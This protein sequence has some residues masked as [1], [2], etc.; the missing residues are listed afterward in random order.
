MQPLM[1]SKLGPLI[2]SLIW[3]N[4]G[5]QRDLSQPLMGYPIGVHTGPLMRSRP[6]CYRGPDQAPND[7][8]NGPL[9]RSRLGPE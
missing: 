9:M 5:F 4:L 6:D 3:F 7:V 1:K 2:G 8:Q